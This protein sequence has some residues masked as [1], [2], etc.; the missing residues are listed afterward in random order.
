MSSMRV[1]QYTECSAHSA[2]SNATVFCALLRCCPFVYIHGAFSLPNLAVRF[3][4]WLIDPIPNNCFTSLIVR[5]MVEES[6]VDSWNA[7]DYLLGFGPFLEL[8]C[9]IC[10][11][12][13][14]TIPNRFIDRYRELRLVH[15]CDLCDVG[16]V[17]KDWQQVQ[18]LLFRS[19][20][21][22][23]DMPRDSA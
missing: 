22:I 7:C 4:P 21:R 16:S 3:K 10:G 14:D 17:V 6:V 23:A 11:T 19:F 2:H 8:T 9:F 20:L 15:F 18:T 13:F 12:R 5:P 1:D